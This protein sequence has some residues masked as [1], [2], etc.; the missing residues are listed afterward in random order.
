MDVV[1]EEA[2]A[3]LTAL[4]IFASRYGQNIERRIRLGEAAA[5]ITDPRLLMT[6]LEKHMFQGAEIVMNAVQMPVFELD[7]DESGEQGD[8]SEE[9]HTEEPGC[10]YDG[11]LLWEN[12]DFTVE[13]R[14]EGT[15]FQVIVLRHVFSEDDQDE[16]VIRNSGYVTSFNQVLDIC[17]RLDE[18]DFLTAMRILF[19]SYAGQTRSEKDLDLIARTSVVQST[20][21]ALEL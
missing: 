8:S 19:A 11:Y 12:G 14:P 13:I 15:E 20:I 5:D 18:V 17:A 10:N 4:I 21:S 3:K 16:V 7:D 9:T 2:R 6:T 1:D